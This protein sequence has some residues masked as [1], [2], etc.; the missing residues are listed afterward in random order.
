VRPLIDLER[1]R[2]R[3]YLLEHSISWREDSTNNALEI[4]RNRIRHQTLPALAAEWNPALTRTLAQTADWALAEEAYWEAELDRRSSG[5]LMHRPPA[6]LMPAATLD[7]LEPAFAR[8]LIRRAICMVR[9]DLRSIEFDHVQQILSLTRDR[10]G[11]GRVQ[12]PKVDVMRSFDW[13]RFA[14]PPPPGGEPR[15]YRMTLPQGESITLPRGLVRTE[16]A[17]K[18]APDLGVDYRYNGTVSYLDWE[19]V[20]G[21]LEIRNWRPGD[22]YQ[23]VGHSGPEKIKTLFQRARVPLWERRSWPVVVSAEEIV[24][25]RRF[26]PAAAFAAGTSTRKVLIIDDC[27]V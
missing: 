22:Q 19:Q 23:P 4:A 5:I 20:S 12:I 1:E 27:E 10:E 16:V 13:L 7:G 9:G 3:E 17:E 15:D 26:G 14:P 8:R 18:S 2:I 24:W 25:A 21:H 11:S 6:V